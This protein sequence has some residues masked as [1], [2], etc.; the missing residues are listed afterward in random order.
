MSVS[1]IRLKLAQ[2]K[3]KYR[4]RG[5]KWREAK[6]D[7]KSFII[8]KSAREYV[9]YFKPAKRW[10]KLATLRHSGK[11]RLYLGTKRLQAVL[12]K[13]Q[14]TRRKYRTVY[15]HISRELGGAPWQLRPRVMRRLPQWVRGIQFF[16]DER[17]LHRKWKQVAVWYAV[18]AEGFSDGAVERDKKAWYVDAM[19]L[20]VEPM[21]IVSRSLAL[22]KDIVDPM[23]IGDGGVVQ[24][25]NVEVEEKTAMYLWRQ[26]YVL[27]G[28]EGVYEVSGDVGLRKPR[29][30]P[31]T[32]RKV[33]RARTHRRV[34]HGD[35]RG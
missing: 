3:V 24:S 34:R 20:Q 5:K 15:E 2:Y 31:R 17:D 19:Y 28:V 33:S 16:D 30:K 14:K 22:F 26:H 32:R 23:I 9:I 12:Q 21:R 35:R 29:K 11:S 6:Q 27:L 7:K 4:T 10:L 25:H 18:E 13:P 1:L 8:P